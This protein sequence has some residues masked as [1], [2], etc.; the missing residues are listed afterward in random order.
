MRETPSWKQR[1]RWD[2][3]LF[4]QDIFDNVAMGRIQSWAYQWQACIWMN[5]GNSITPNVNLVMNVG[6]AGDGTN[7]VDSSSE[8]SRMPIG[9][10]ERIADPA[11]LEVNPKADRYVFEWAYL[12]GKRPIIWVA[13]M[14]VKSIGR[15]TRRLISGAHV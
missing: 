10:I 5:N 9:Y 13:K 14:L 8:L 1:F 2:E 12:S 4:W 11:Q 6:F 7:T 15:L 3:R